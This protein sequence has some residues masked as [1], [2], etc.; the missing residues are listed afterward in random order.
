MDFIYS[1]SGWGTVVLYVVVGAIFVVH[2][3]TKMRKPAAIAKAAWGGNTMAGFLHGLVEVLAGLGVMLG[4]FGPWAALAMV[5]IM[6]GALYFKIV[7]WHLSFTGNNGWEF[8]LLLL[9]GAL[10]I[11]LG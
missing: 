7:K 8:D 6:A 4:M 1:Y 2:G 3:I 5:V 10:T 9:A 11:L